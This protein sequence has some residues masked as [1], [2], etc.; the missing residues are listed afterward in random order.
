M[1]DSLGGISCSSS[2]AVALGRELTDRQWHQEQMA[3]QERDYLAQEIVAP[4]AEPVLDLLTDEP[5][6]WQSNWGIFA[7]G[8]GYARAFIRALRVR[9]GSVVRYS[10]RETRGTCVFTCPRSVR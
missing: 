6:H 7:T 5:E 1:T 8:A 4:A 9:A 3:V 10:N 2:T